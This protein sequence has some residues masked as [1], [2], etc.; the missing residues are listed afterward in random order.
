MSLPR[1]HILAV[2]ILLGLLLA[3]GLQ[4]YD[5]LTW[6]MEVMPVLIAI[7]VLACTWRRYPLTGLLYALIFVHCVILIYGGEYT[8][9]RVPLGFWLQDMLG[10]LRN[11]YDKIGHFAQGF[12]PAMIAR[13]I[14]V[15]GAYVQGRTMLAFL[16]GCVAM[17]ISAWYE[18][19]EWAAALVMGQGAD[20]FLG[21]QG[22]QWDTQSDMFLA[23]LGAFCAL[24]LL[25]RWHDRLLARQMGGQAG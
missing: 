3:S 8:Y 7:P 24:M 5:R 10:T 15:R 19:I 4:P 17:A 11:P 20:E 2:L 12:V 16:S 6:L 23:F 22:D 1:V 14:F 9:A 13:E 18:I 25:S 21:L